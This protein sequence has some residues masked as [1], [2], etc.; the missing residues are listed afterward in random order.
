[1]NETFTQITKLYSLNHKKTT[2]YHP[3]TNGLTER[4]NKT[5]AD[6]IS[7]FVAEDHKDWDRFLPHLLFAFNTSIHESTGYSPF[8][9]L[10][11]YEA[12][13]MID[14]AL[15]LP[16]AGKENQFSFENIIYSQ[17][18]RKIAAERQEIIQE[19]FSERF[20]KQ[21]QENTFKP[22]DQ[23]WVKFP[24]RKPGRSEKIL[25][26]YRGP[27]R[28]ISQ[29]APNNFEIIDSKGKSDIVNVERFKPY[30]ERISSNVPNIRNTKTN[31]KV[32]FND[33]V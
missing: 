21:R 9:L 15:A 14:Q 20:D 13:L 22:G 26:Q 31:K 32:S 3:R 1:M 6:M 24:T 19:R 23:V 18:A 33:L 2:S 5:L 30:H 12:D 4:F 10:H 11:G 25:H 17:K 29:T 27:Y 16:N 7:H 28:I 8:F